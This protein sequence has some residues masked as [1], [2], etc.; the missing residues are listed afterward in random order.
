MVTGY[1]QGEYEKAFVS[2]VYNRLS[3]SLFKVPVRDLNSVKAYRREVMD[4][5]P[6]R[7]DWH[8]YMIV[9]AAAQGFTVTEV[10]VPLYARHA[11]KSKFG[12]GRIPVGVIDMLAVW[13]ELRFA[14]K[15]LLLFGMLGAALFTLGVIAGVAA[16]IWLL[17]TGEGIRAVWTVIQSCL[18]L[19]S[20]FFSTGFIGELVAAQR[21]ETRELRA[22][23]EELAHG[24]DS[25]LKP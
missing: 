10:P 7:P 19:G 18:I 17:V 2:G 12:I 25:L 16:V 22:R 15:P 8:R 23:I 3:R 14:K 4:S 20:V 5:I 24:R 13:F 1:K 9:V 11:G 6:A 21:A